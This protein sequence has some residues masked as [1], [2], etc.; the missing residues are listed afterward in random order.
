MPFKH[1]HV[2]YAMV[3]R[4]G[5]LGRWLGLDKVLRLYPPKTESWWPYIGRVREVER[6][7]HTRAL[8]PVSLRTL[9]ARR[10]LNCAPWELWAGAGEKSLW[11]G[12]LCCSCREPGCSSQ[13]PLGNSQSCLIP[14]PGAWCPL[15]ASGAS[16]T[17][18][19]CRYIQAKHSH[20]WN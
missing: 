11:W 18:C 6:D 17:H 7:T 5:A 16:S 9:P 13:H 2:K 10:H 15:L 4:D 8:C 14:V 1:S 12:A 19:T 20:T 3:F